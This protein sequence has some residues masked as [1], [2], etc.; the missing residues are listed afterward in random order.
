MK[1]SILTSIIQAPYL[2]RLT[3]SF[4]WIVA[5]SDSRVWALDMDRVPRTDDE[6]KYAVMVH[7]CHSNKGNM[8]KLC[9]QY[10][11]IFTTFL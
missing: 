1:E 11:N 3:D 7:N 4:T 2:Q 9:Q 5:I 6:P 8:P 10:L